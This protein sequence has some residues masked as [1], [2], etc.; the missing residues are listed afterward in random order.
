[1][2]SNYVIAFDCFKNNTFNFI[3][4]FLKLFVQKIRTD[5]FLQRVL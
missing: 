3:H 5:I 4:S 1:M 2:I